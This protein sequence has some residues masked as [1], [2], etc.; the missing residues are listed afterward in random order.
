MT[1][2][3]VVRHVA[4]GI[5]GSGEMSMKRRILRLAMLSLLTG[6]GVLTC[7]PGL[8]QE[9]PCANGTAQVQPEDTLSRIANRCDVSEGAILAANPS[10]DGSGDLQVGATLRLQPATSQSQRLGDRLNHFAREANDAVGRIAGQV[11]SSA[12][13]LLDKNPDLKSR[14]ERLGQRFGLGDRAG[15]PSLSLTPNQGPAGS[16]VTLSA[17][18][19]PKDEPLMIGVGAPNTAFQVLRS[20]RTSDKGTLDADVKVPE[21]QGSTSLVFVLRSGDAVKLTSKPFRVVP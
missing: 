13:D 16:K 9:A 4:D 6:M 7:D 3:L 8:A 20:A 14:L 15:A 5:E 19:L 1:E 17:T 18:G 2:R 12:Q 11:G 10:I 21:R